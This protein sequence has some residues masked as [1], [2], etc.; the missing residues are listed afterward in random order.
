MG[1]GDLI[2][3]E[4]Y[5]TTADGWSLRLR[6]TLSPSH[7]DPNTKPL[8]IVPGYGMNS[9]IFSY[10][11]RGTSM[12]RCLAEGGYEVWAMD[13]RGQ[14]QSFAEKTRPGATT[15]ANYATVDVP[16]AI[17]RVLSSTTTSA[18]T[19]TL[20]GCS[21]GGSIAYGYLAVTGARRVS[22]VIAMGA[23]LRWSEVHPLI[24]IAFASPALA[25]RL[26]IS[27]T[28]KWLRSAFPLIERF[29]S[30][31]GM[32][33]NP[34]S[35]DTSDMQ[36]MTQTVEDPDPQVNRDIAVW[37]KGR[38]LY[39]DGVNITAAMAHM[40]LPLFVVLS[41]KDGIVPAS[42]A[43]TAADAWGGPNVEVLEVGDDTNWYA[44][45]NLFV[46]DDAPQLVFDPIIDWLRRHA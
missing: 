12:E 43:L 3:R 22:E 5:V 23:P 41:N 38:D 17:E 30:L 20:V 36:A 33:M 32:Y 24:K 10:H 27:N 44:H 6:H 1:E 40:T 4:Q 31:L 39:L 13:L 29:P 28:R 15:L 7:F 11:P 2:I 19:V 26:K 42:T 18:Q 34:A 45:A 35:I 37:I 46:A 21:L 16:A 25:A 9:F 8:L 14:G